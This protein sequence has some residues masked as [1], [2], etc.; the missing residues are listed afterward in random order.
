MQLKFSTKSL[1]FLVVFLRSFSGDRTH[2][3]RFYKNCT[4]LKRRFFIEN[5]PI[6]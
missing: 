3:S 1:D 4:K 6:D 5:M 2:A